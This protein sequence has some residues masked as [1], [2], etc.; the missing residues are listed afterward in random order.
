MDW[1]EVM[2]GTGL[3]HEGHVSQFQGKLT[4]GFRIMSDDEL[5]GV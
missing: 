1:L 2:R 5:K 3:L 4:V